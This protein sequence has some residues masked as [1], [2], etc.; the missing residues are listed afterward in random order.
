[1]TVLLCCLAKAC[2]CCLAAAAE[3]PWWRASHLKETICKQADW[4][5][6][7]NLMSATAALCTCRT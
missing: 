3:M 1:M 7:T 5:L 6:S 2:R 4:D